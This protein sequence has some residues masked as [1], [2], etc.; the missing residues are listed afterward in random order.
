MISN[1]ERRKISK[2]INRDFLDVEGFQIEDIRSWKY[3]MVIAFLSTDV[4]ILNNKP[5]YNDVKKIIRIIENSLKRMKQLEIPIILK[6]I[7]IQTIKNPKN[8]KPIEELLKIFNYDKNIFYMIK[9]KYLYLPNIP[10]IEEGEKKEILNYSKYKKR[11][12]DILDL[13]NKTNNYNA[14]DSLIKY[15]DKFNSAKMEINCLIIKQY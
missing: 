12:E 13:L 4:I 1:E 15:I 3:V 2:H 6:N 9:L 11:F 14:V 5:R 10:E 8:Q 7:D